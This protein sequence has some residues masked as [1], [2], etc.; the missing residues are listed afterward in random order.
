M[1]VTARAIV[2]YAES[3][4]QVGRY[5]LLLASAREARVSQAAMAAL[6][7]DYTKLVEQLARDRATLDEQMESK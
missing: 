1:Q 5:E 3:G 2:D 6:V 4:R 7:N